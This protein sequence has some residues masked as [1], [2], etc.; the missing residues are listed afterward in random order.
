MGKVRD[1]RISYRD[2]GEAVSKVFTSLGGRIKGL[3][4]KFDGR[5]LWA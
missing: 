4:W 3:E 5:I 1:Y 2:R